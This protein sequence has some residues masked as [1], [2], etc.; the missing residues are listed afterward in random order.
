MKNLPHIHR[1]N[2][3]DIVQRERRNTNE[4]LP[5]RYN[6]FDGSPKS[7]Q[8]LRTITQPDSADKDA[9]SIEETNSD[10]SLSGRDR[11][12][13]IDSP[14]TRSNLFYESRGQSTSSNGN[15]IRPPISIGKR[16]DLLDKIHRQ[17]S[18]RLSQRSVS[19]ADT[20]VDM[21]MSPSLNK[22]PESPIFQQRTTNVQTNSNLLL[23][24]SM[25]TDAA[26]DTNPNSPGISTPPTSSI[27]EKSR[28][29]PMLMTKAMPSSSGSDKVS[30]DS[31]LP[32]ASD[33]MDS[34][35]EYDIE[36]KDKPNDNDTPSS[37]S[38][39]EKKS[40]SARTLWTTFSTSMR[41]MWDA[42]DGH[43]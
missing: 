29:K 17:N 36:R 14:V 35:K 15:V 40:L 18:A 25:S 6:P 24:R 13:T 11:S 3:S 21:D 30:I 5:V 41:N 42:I 31:E 23:E 1:L 19:S 32:L 8:K 27:S 12:N 28:M 26:H 22:S 9:T 33:I 43:Y 37:S 16:M 39:S 20:T 2:S 10:L 4:E 38:A 34:M 7:G